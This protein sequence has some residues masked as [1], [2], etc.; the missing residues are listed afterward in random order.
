MA[1]KKFKGSPFQ[2]GDKVLID[3]PGYGHSGSIITISRIE[4]SVIKHYE[5]FYHSK[6]GPCAFDTWVK[7]PEFH[8]NQKLLKDAMGIKDS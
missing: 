3:W 6:E 4:T 8:I 7:S 5:Y 2:I 1:K